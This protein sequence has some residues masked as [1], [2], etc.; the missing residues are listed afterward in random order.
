MSCNGI[1]PGLSRLLYNDASVCQSP[2]ASKAH[3][4]KIQKHHRFEGPSKFP[5]FSHKKARGPIKVQSVSEARY[6]AEVI[7]VHSSLVVPYS[8]GIKFNL[9]ECFLHYEK[10]FNCQSRHLIRTA[11]DDRGVECLN[12]ELG[13]H[14]AA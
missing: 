6:F 14:F 11:F 7:D 9:E 13:Y 12:I 1:S 4:T 2:K 10:I 8:I 5:E 3:R